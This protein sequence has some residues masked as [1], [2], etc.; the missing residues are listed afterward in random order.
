MN[1]NLC[2]GGLDCEVLLIVFVVVAS[3]FD[4]FVD[5]FNEPFCNKN[6]SIKFG[7]IEKLDGSVNE[8]GIGGGGGK[9]W[10]L[11]TSKLTVEGLFVWWILLL[12]EFPRFCRLI[13][14][15]SLRN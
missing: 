9:G 6:K 10:V 15:E 11:I 7:I 1:S 4:V 14:S 12:F 2:T 3:V 8:P 13:S 5:C